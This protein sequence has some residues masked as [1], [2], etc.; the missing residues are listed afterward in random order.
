MSH[1][2][3]SLPAVIIMGG[4]LLCSTSSFG[5]PEYTKQTKKACTFCHQT[6]EPGK[7]DVMKGNLTEA[8]KYF[9]EH[10]NLDGY[11]KK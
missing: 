11:Q 10:Q 2:K 5:K 3:L 9:Q 4:F 6:N 7:K 8:G 1:L